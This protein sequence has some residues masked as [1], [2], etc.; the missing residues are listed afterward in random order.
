MAVLN[1]Y[2]LPN[3]VVPAN[4]LYVGRPSP[5]GNPYK[6]PTSGD[7]EMAVYMFRRYAEAVVAETPDWL[8]PLRGKDLV[9][10]CAPKA[11]HADVLEELINA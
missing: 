4:A 2:H 8:E 6:A 1:M 9:C 5:W 7:R 11:C 3:R 10:W